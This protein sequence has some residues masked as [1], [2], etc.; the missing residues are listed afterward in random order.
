MIGIPISIKSSEKG[1]QIYEKTAGV[2]KSIIKEKK[3]KHDKIALL[4]NIKLSSIE[5]LISRTFIDW[6]IIQENFF[7]V[8]NTLKEYDG[9][10]KA[11]KNRK[12]LTVHQRIQS[13]YKTMLS[14]CLKG[15]K[16]ESKNPKFSKKNKRK[17][18]LLSKFAVCDNK[19]SRFI[20]SRS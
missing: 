6:Y 19:N 14:Y 4:A 15:Q 12:T 8:N 16:V 9:M 5:V 1:L 17:L 18:I 3:K 20:K 7:S 10:K 11:I 13:V 2:K